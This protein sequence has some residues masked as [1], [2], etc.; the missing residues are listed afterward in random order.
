MYLSGSF[1]PVCRNQQLAP[2]TASTRARK[3]RQRAWLGGSAICVAPNPRLRTAGPCCL[4]RKTKLAPVEAVVGAG[5]FAGETRLKEPERYMNHPRRVVIMHNTCGRLHR[6][7]LQAPVM[8]MRAVLWF[9]DDSCTFLIP[10]A[11]VRDANEGPPS[12]CG[13][14]KHALLVGT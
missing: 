12:V 13:H 6:P 14:W 1:R 2:T 7:P 3:R 11:S 8:E 5:C 4:G 9:F 10:H